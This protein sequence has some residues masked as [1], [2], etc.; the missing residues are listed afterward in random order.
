MKKIV[1]FISFLTGFLNDC[2]GQA[3]QNSKSY[4]TIIDSNVKTEVEGY[5]N[6]NFKNENEK[7]IVVLKFQ[8][9]KH[10]TSNYEYYIS[11]ILIKSSLK[12]VNPIAFSMIDGHLILLFG[13]GDIISCKKN[14]YSRYI[15]K[16]LI[17]DDSW[18]SKNK[19]IRISFDPEI[20]KITVKNNMIIAK[21]ELSKQLDLRSKF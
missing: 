21:E 16:H 12:D 10:N 4:C 1:L 7:G 8:N 17:N 19:R 11:M 18:T 13:L 5:I 20:L 14:M 9:E 15:K 2:N 3:I 6:R